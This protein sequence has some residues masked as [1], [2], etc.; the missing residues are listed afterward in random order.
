MYSAK[1]YHIMY[2]N[3]GHDNKKYNDNACVHLNTLNN[4]FLT[5]RITVWV[6]NRL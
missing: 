2:E 4:I 3:I 6:Y 1:L 5:Y